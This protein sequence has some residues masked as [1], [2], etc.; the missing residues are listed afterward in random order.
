MGSDD[1]AGVGLKT[2]QTSVIYE[3]FTHYNNKVK[4]QHYTTCKTVSIILL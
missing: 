4:S 1:R 2:I 3:P